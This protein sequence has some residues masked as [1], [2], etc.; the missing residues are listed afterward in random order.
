MRLLLSLA[1]VACVT[2]SDLPEPAGPPPD[3][4]WPETWMGKDDTGQVIVIMTPHTWL[5]VQDYLGRSH[6]WMRQAE[7]S[8]ETCRQ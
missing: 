4:S 7:A 6:N 2:S 8:L 5:E 1:L 3:L